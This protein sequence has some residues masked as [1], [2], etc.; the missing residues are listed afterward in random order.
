MISLKRYNIITVNIAIIILYIVSGYLGAII[1]NLPGNITP[2]WPPAGLSLAAIILFNRKI[3]PAIY[4][5]SLGLSAALGQFEL[6]LFSFGIN[7]LASTFDVM[8]P[9]VGKFILKKLK[10]I[11]NLFTKLTSV[12]KFIGLSFIISI[13][14]CTLGSTLFYLVEFIPAEEFLSTLGIWYAGDVIGM[15]IYTPFI[16]TL[17]STASKKLTSKEQILTAIVFTFTIVYSIIIF[18]FTDGENIFNSFSEYLF[19]PLILSVAYLSGR[20]T[21]FSLIVITQCLATYGTTLGYGPFISRYGYLEA[22]VE[23]QVFLVIEAITILIISVF[24]AERNQ[25]LRNVFEEKNKSQNLIDTAGSLLIELDLNGNIILFNKKAEELIGYTSDEVIGKNW[26]EFGLPEEDK[27]KHLGIFKENINGHLAGLETYDKRILTKSGE[28]KFF[29]WHNSLVRDNEGKITGRLS[30]GIDI[31]DK[32]K[33]DDELEEYR[34][35]LESLVDVRTKELEKAKEIAEAATKA[36]SEFL[37][38]MS[39]EIRTPMNEIIGYSHILKKS[40][41]NK[42]QFDYA[43]KIQSGAVSLL[44]IINEILDFSKIEAGK[45]RFENIEFKLDSVLNSLSTG[46]SLSAQNKGLELIF[47]VDKKIPDI[48]IGDPLR[49]KQV[50]LNLCSNSVKFTERGEV[51]IK[52]S[53]KEI[54]E[55]KCK[56]VFSVKDTGI[57]MTK[58]Q[59]GNLFNAFSQADMSTTRKYGGT[60][61]GLTISQRLV[62][63]MGGKIELESEFGKGSNFYF[64]SEFGIAKEKEDKNLKKDLKEITGLKI[65]VCDDNSTSR[66][67]IDESLKAFGIN[68]ELATNGLEAL[69]KLESQTDQPFDLLIIDYMMPEINGFETIELIKHNMN[70]KKQPKLLV[71]TAYNN[72]E[73][74]DILENSGVKNYLIKPFSYSSLLDEI[75]NIFGKQIKSKVTGEDSKNIDLFN[76]FRGAHILIVD[77]NNINREVARD[78]LEEAELEI[79]EATNGK[80]ALE[81]IIHSSDENPYDIVLID[82]QMPIMDGYEATKK[83]REIE[84]FKELPVIALTADAVTGTIEKCK[85]VG[86]T[87]FIS[88]P[89]DPKELYIKLAKWTKILNPNKKSEKI[90]KEKSPVIKIVQTEKINY[91]EAL[92]RFNENKKILHKILIKFSDNYKNFE[93]D[94]KNSFK[95]N[96]KDSTKRLVHTLKGLAGTIC[97]SELYSIA[98]E[99]DEK[100]LK[101]LITNDINDFKKLINELNLVIKEINGLNLLTEEKSSAVD[102]NLLTELSE[103]KQ[104]ITDSDYV[105]INI[106]ERLQTNIDDKYKHYIT[107]IMKR[108]KLF[109]FEKAKE[110]FD[111]FINKE[112]IKLS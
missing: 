1:S 76:K 25:I 6:T 63:M 85:D 14:N 67:V 82:L 16:I 112:D 17:F 89:I 61:L 71:I 62:N 28:I 33:L 59:M 35:H 70:I 8:Q 96:D 107:E 51:V 19:I 34:E 20:K 108:V 15:L 10:I 40:E 50:L 41:L 48:L 44:E 13:I 43:T 4:L 29:N 111:N 30:S 73:F 110:L 3:I 5:G 37:A 53:L 36:K 57:G 98:V 86:M 27:E 95:S 101:N 65:L 47:D 31:T 88:K 23:L 52:I 99:T 102:I 64:T 18:I 58:E 80:E 105:A 26:F 87:D 21:A 22:L 69:G 54:S 39:H 56:I 9:L 46:I 79:D 42:K 75:L 72:E 32:K 93:Y 68:C 81:K 12:L 97:A 103:L 77:D 66:E 38:N 2:V 45:L 100:I 78:L 49:L 11:E 84:K 74:Q 104:K 7:L 91:K 92:S 24:R 55:N 94:L 109:D 83:L 106:L 60:G 90:I